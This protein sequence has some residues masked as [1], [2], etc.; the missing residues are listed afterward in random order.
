MLRD[1]RNRTYYVYPSW[2]DLSYRWEDLPRLLADPLNSGGF[3]GE[4]RAKEKTKME[5][6]LD[7]GYPPKPNLRLS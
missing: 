7:A 3:K 4:D 6:W 1:E 2:A 5:Y